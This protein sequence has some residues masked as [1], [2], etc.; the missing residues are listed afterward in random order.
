[1]QLHKFE[2]VFDKLNT[3]L[4]V[5]V[6][7]RGTFL[8]ML[9]RRRC[10]YQC[11]V[12]RPWHW[13]TISIRSGICWDRNRIPRPL[14]RWPPMKYRPQSMCHQ[15]RTFAHPRMC[16]R[17]R[18]HLRLSSN[19]LGLLVLWRRFVGNSSHPNVRTMFPSQST[20]VGWRRHASSGI[21]GT[22]NR[23][24]RI[25]PPNTLGW[26][27]IPTVRN[28]HR[29]MLEWCVGDSTKQGSNEKR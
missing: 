19:Y 5:L 20:S 23:F 25:S 8:W 15:L 2:F 7:R 18:M 9:E 3:I 22:T 21:L 13:R 26:H 17:N 10:W 4:L 24:C 1:M 14:K 28:L 6:L 29:P 11:R 27:A 16:S 12:W